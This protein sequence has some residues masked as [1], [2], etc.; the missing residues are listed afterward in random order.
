MDAVEAKT[1]STDNSTVL[2]SPL[3]IKNTTR[4]EELATDVA[5][6]NLKISQLAEELQ[7]KDAGSADFNSTVANNW[8]KSKFK[9]F[10][11]APEARL[12]IKELIETKLMS[13]QVH[14]TLHDKFLNN[15]FR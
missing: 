1:S 10:L 5:K 4:V 9:A 14:F 7:K 3:T 6:I 12:Y 8:F 2:N 13:F 11:Q 15:L